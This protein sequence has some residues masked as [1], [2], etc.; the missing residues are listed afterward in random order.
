MTFLIS[1]ESALQAIR[2]R[3]TKWDQ[4]LEA[5][6]FFVCDTKATVYDILRNMV[7]NR[8]TLAGKEDIQRLVSLVGLIQ[9]E[10]GPFAPLDRLETYEEMLQRLSPIIGLS[11]E[12]LVASYG[13]FSPE[14]KAEVRTAESMSAGISQDLSGDRVRGRLVAVHRMLLGLGHKVL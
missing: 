8:G 14:A 1:V 13:E 2:S 5:Y 10:P 7:D 3:S 11:F 9:R 6:R 12:T 4:I